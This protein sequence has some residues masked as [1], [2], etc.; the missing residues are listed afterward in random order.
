MSSLFSV[1]TLARDAMAA[2]SA[3][4][5]VT[6]Q[7]IANVSTPGFVRRS[8]L[9]E[10]R[11]GSPGGVFASGVARA[12]DRATFARAVAEGGRRE[13]ASARSGSLARVEALIV[14]SGAPSIGDRVGDLFA[15]FSDLAQKAD[16][17]TARAVVLTRAGD[18]AS[19]ISS[20][21][22]D[23]DGER[24]ALLARAQGVAAE[25]NQD[26]A[27]IGDLNQQIATAQASGVDALDLRDERDR[28]VRAVGERI[29]VKPVEDGTGQVTL[30]SSGSVLLTANEA[31]TVSVGV[32]SGGALLVQIAHGSA[33]PVDVTSRVTSG[34]LGGIREARDVDLTALAGQLDQL[35]YDLANGVNAVHTSGFGLDGVSGRPLFAPPSGVTGAALALAI[36][37]SVAG[38]PDAIAASSLASNLPGGNDLALALSALAHAPLGAA[39]SPAEAFASMAA[40]L[41]ARKSAADAELSLRDATTFQLEQ[42]I[43]SVSGVSVDE[44]MV[45]LTQF[46]RAFE[47]SL[48]V[49]RTANELF[50]ELL[51]L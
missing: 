19:A 22:A 49:L 39:A 12:F 9:L 21:A 50:D 26:L 24:S 11:A 25:L 28:L 10:T 51:R 1:L 47:A 37:P 3:G 30:L 6:G 34:E 44:E 27:R 33:P 16:D 46:Q 31:G 18:V 7:N 29:D 14:P 36:D 15:A 32:D 40:D 20:A 42:L 48:T 17:S 41:G 13:S 5:H 35:A 8:L 43:G 4:L 45:Q 23:I 2:Q 38:Q